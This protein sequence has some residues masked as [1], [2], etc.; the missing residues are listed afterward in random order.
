MY[1]M[2][3]RKF[4]CDTSRSFLKDIHSYPDN[5]SVTCVLGYDV[6]YTAFRNKFTMQRK[7]TGD[8]Y[9]SRMLV[10]LPETPMDIRYANQK[11]EYGISSP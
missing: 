3:T 5:I 10:L 4:R 8:G 7:C 11:S 1:G 2:V 9:C 6:D